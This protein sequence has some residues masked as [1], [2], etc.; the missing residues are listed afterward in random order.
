MKLGF[1]D[2]PPITLSMGFAVVMLLMVALGFVGL[3]RM[4]N[5]YWH[6]EQIVKDRN[7]KKERA[8]VMKDALRERALLMHSIS[9][10]TDAFDQDA[11]FLIFNEKGIE[12]VNARHGLESMELSEGEK[13][14]LARI[15]VLTQTTQ[16][17]VTLAVDT[18]MSG[19]PSRAQALIREKAIPAQKAIAKE[20]DN[21]I[22]LEYSETEMAWNQAAESYRSARLMILGL[23]TAAIGLGLLI[24]FLVV[25]NAQ[26]QASS[27]H[28]QAMFDGLTN[29]PNRALFADRLQQ[30]ILISRR[31]NQSFALIAMDL[32]RF[33]EINDS[34]GHHV[35]DEVLQQVTD[36]SRRCLRSSDTYARMGGDEFTILL[37]NT[38]NM[39]DATIVAKK[40]LGAINTPIIIAD[41]HLE[42]SASLGIALFPEHG[43]NAV[44]LLR[45]AD[46]AMYEA[47]RTQ[48]GYTF[49][50]AN[51]NQHAADRMKLQGE[52]RHAIDHNELVLHYQ[53]KI[54]LASSHIIGVEALV[55]WQH[56]TRGLLFP[57]TFIDLAETTG[58][59]KALTLEVLKQALCQS[60]I[61]YKSG[62]NLTVAVNISTLNIQDPQ[63]PDQIA[64]LLKSVSM[65]VSQLE[66]EITETAIMTG[67]TQAVI[68]IKRLNDL[69]LQIAIDD[70]GTGY[71]S[72]SRL[73][74]FLV[75]QIK[76]DKSFVKDMAVNHNDAV[77][78][79]STVELGH[80]LGMK[81][82]A[83]GVEDKATWDELK[84]L[85]CDSA[86]GYYMSRPLTVEKFQLWLSESR[87]G[88]PKLDELS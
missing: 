49:Y 40:I 42:I 51:L 55:R 74:E 69:G 60:E 34:F 59:I 41:Q 78:V 62:L 75:A 6:M 36:Q 3:T 64:D 47:K 76:I 48:S 61:W 68:C 85:G 17:L 35:G 32:D 73:K 1:K 9:V 81:V 67:A 56:P 66:M 8:Q 53:P 31:E 54:D 16:P 46:A 18:A 65:P 2:S 28:H 57:D 44:V 7:V 79:R 27:L 87:W 12:Y 71:S 50:N 58:L 84:S 11:E 20:I 15:Q 14:I 24:A 86:Q 33:K 52:L 19:E 39:K 80:S 43:D 10:L 5:L 30:A 45:N 77:I 21:L 37:P 29:L 63:F 13:V 25:R 23:G 72:M 70:F 4:A 83:E 88:Y 26:R 82:I 22:S 38:S